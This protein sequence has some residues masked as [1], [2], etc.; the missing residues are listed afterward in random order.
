MG[1]TEGEP[2]NQKVEDKAE[3]C[4]DIAIGVNNDQEEG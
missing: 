4:G 3:K 1:L 2:D